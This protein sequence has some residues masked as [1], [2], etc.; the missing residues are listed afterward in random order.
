MILPYLFVSILYYYP[1]TRR[2]LDPVSCFDSSSGEAVP[3]FNPTWSLTSQPPDVPP[4]V[5]HLESVIQHLAERR[6]EFEVFGDIRQVL[7]QVFWDG[8]EAGHGG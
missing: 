8:L 2:T 1:R 7:H 4:D 6:I 3:T 5:I